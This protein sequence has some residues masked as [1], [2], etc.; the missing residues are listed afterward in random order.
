MTIITR[1]ACE[2]LASKLPY[3]TINVPNIETGI[4]EPYLTRHYLFGAD[5]EFGNIYLHHFHASD[6]GLEFHSHPFAW[7]FGLILV[8]G[9]IEERLALDGT[10]TSKIVKPGSI[11]YITNKIFHRVDLIEEDCWTLFF[12]GPRTQDWGF[13]DR[14]TLKFR[15]WRSNPNAI[16]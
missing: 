3:T 15:D 4:L 9:Y 6:Q 14:E 8:G 10:V 7:S 16:S 5:R 12:A 1:Q 2:K 13:K 11:N